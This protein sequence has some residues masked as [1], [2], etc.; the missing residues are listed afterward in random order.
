[1]QRLSPEDRVG[2]KGRKKMVKK[3]QGGKQTD[4]KRRRM[5]RGSPNT[6]GREGGQGGEKI[7]VFA[8]LNPITATGEPV[9]KG[10][11]SCFEIPPYG[12]GNSAGGIMRAL[13]QLKKWR[14]L[15]GKG[16]KRQPKDL[17]NR[18]GRK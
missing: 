11:H 1:M 2:N 14:V 9:R 3:K 6:K 12:R 10:G 8:A 16:E 15:D 13:G 5:K 4:G 7:V 17:P 18:Q